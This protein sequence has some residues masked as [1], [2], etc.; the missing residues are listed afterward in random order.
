MWIVLWLIPAGG[1][2]VVG[3]FFAFRFFDIVKPPPVRHAEMVRG[4]WGIMLDDLLAALY[5]VASIRALLWIG[6]LSA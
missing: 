3:G 5:T 1:W 6:L 2:S 4:G